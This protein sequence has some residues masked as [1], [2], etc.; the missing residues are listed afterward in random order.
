M[1]QLIASKCGQADLLYTQYWDTRVRPNRW[2]MK[3]RA[4]PYVH[5]LGSTNTCQTYSGTDRSCDHITSK[6][7][8]AINL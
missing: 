5:L 6:F 2:T 7:Y 8:V 4:F 3:L 1:K